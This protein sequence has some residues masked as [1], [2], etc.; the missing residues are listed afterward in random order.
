MN[1]PNKLTVFRIIMIPF[2]IAAMLIE[3]LPHHFIIA[4]VL[5][6]AAFVTDT[7]DGKIA[8]KYNLIT[9]FGKMMDPL[10]DKMLT[11]SVLI[12]FLDLKVAPCIAVVLIIMREL[13]VTSLRMIALEKGMVI[14]AD[15]FG[16]IKTVYQSVALSV[17]LFL[18]ELSTFPSIADKIPISLITNILMWIMATITVLSGANYLIKNRGIIIQ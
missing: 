1:L 3:T 11:I 7:L 4:L 13:I 6:I 14:A 5:F 9:D 2:C 8:R 15:I 17:M 16:K 12:C 10:A 18:C